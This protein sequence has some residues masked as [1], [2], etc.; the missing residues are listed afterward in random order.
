[1]RQQP[2]LYNSKKQ[3]KFVEDQTYKQSIA[4]PISGHS[5]MLVNANGNIDQYSGHALLENKD[6]TNKVKYRC[7]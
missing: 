1:M 3:L 4:F 2:V 5:G 6:T 7:L